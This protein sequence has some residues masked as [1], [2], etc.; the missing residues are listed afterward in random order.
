M[1]FVKNVFLPQDVLWTLKDREVSGRHRINRYADEVGSDITKA[2]G[3]SWINVVGWNQSTVS[4]SLLK[5]SVNCCCCHPPWGCKCLSGGMNG[6]IMPVGGWFQRER[7]EGYVW[8]Q[9]CEHIDGEQVSSGVLQEASTCISFEIQQDT[10]K[11]TVTNFLMLNYCLLGYF[12]T[13][14]NVP[15]RIVLGVFLC[16]FFPKVF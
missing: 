2:D 12:W 4:G 8:V 16:F 11:Q 15:W 9:K 3:W 10:W 7:E 14:I 1:H 5:S 13:V 6:R